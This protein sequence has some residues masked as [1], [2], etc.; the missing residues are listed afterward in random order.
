MA[1]FDLP[2]PEEKVLRFVLYRATSQGEPTK[3]MDV[4]RHVGRD[5]DPLLKSLVALG[6]LR[7]VR[8]VFLPSLEAILI[9]RPD[10]A[11]PLD[12]T[13]A[14]ASEAFR[15]RG[16]DVISVDELFKVLRE[17]FRFFFLEADDIDG[18]LFQCALFGLEPF[19][20]V[21]QIGVYLPSMLHISPDIQQLT[22]LE[23]IRFVQRAERLAKGKKAPHALVTPKETGSG[24][25]SAG[26]EP[27]PRPLGHLLAAIVHR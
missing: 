16:R 24:I 1:A 7:P 5:S 20:S 19:I 25:D 14:Y 2:P 12:F 18:F 17:R 21:T 22:K 23:E 27:A 6:W 11:N 13:V 4:D 3:K 8:D 10:I 9:E 15:R 26:S